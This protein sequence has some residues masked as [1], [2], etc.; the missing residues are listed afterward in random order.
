M[1][2]NIPGVALSKPPK[3]T[4]KFAPPGDE[5]VGY[6]SA[7]RGEPAA[8]ASAN[9]FDEMPAVGAAAAGTAFHPGESKHSSGKKV[10]KVEAL[11]HAA[12]DNDVAGGGGDDS[13]YANDRYEDDSQ[14]QQQQDDESHIPVVDR[15][16]KPKSNVYEEIDGGIDDDPNSFRGGGGAPKA[17]ERF[18]E[19]QHPL[20]GVPNCVNLPPPEALTGKSR[21]AIRIRWNLCLP[22][23]E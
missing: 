23:N 5:K 10:A 11:D 3:V 18:P 7:R 9:A 17:V 12:Y 4:N 22:S 21:L 16:I 19:G 20:E 15:V 8:A 1:K 14:F 2:I 13:Y 6:L